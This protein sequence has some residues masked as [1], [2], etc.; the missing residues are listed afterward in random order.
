[1]N[2]ERL[3]KGMTLMCKQEFAD[4]I[5]GSTDVLA[6]RRAAATHRRKTGG[7]LFQLSKPDDDY[8]DNAWWFNEGSGAWQI[9][10]YSNDE[11]RYSQLFEVVDNAAHD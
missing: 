6:T 3:S 2:T 10:E 11:I 5:V 8:P 4:K 7:T 9:S 1:M